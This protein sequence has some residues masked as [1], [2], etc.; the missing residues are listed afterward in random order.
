MK[1]N[2]NDDW[3]WYYWFV[4]GF[5][6]CVIISTA[7]TSQIDTPIKSILYLISILGIQLNQTL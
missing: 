2:K 6:I 7:L 4:Y 3:S 5:W 1:Q